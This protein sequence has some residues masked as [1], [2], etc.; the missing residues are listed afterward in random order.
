[1]WTVEIEADNNEVRVWSDYCSYDGRRPSIFRVSTVAIKYGSGFEVVFTVGEREGEF[2]VTVVSAPFTTHSYSQGQR[3]LRLGTTAPVQTVVGEGFSVVAFAPGNAVLAPQG[4]YML[5][6]VQG[7]IPS[8][9]LWVHLSS[10]GVTNH[11]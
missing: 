4:Y 5:F 2:E 3:M 9:G 1:M 11:V 7:G 8:R 6:A 10:L